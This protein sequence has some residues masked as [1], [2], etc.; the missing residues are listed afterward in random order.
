[1]TR[2]E[3]TIYWLPSILWA[4]AIMYVSTRP[5]DLPAYV[6]SQDKYAHTIVYGV[7]SILLVRSCIFSMKYR[8]YMIPVVV[9]SIITISLYG[10][11]IEVIQIYC[12]RFFEWN[13]II[14][15]TLG[16]VL[17]AIGYGVIAYKKIPVYQ[18]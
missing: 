6:P 12:N 8:G 4:M 13:D 9:F 15:N 16:S 18:D 10:A 1:M 7:M 5:L 2:K 17:G 11:M 14:A 3:F